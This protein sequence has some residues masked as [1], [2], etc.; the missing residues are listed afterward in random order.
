MS[1]S[2]RVVRGSGSDRSS[3]G[4]KKPRKRVVGSGRPATH[5]R[6]SAGDLTRILLGMRVQVRYLVFLSVWNLLMTC[7]ALWAAI[8]G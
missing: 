3:E 2:H 1:G 7:L 4:S 6:L 5:G 8:R